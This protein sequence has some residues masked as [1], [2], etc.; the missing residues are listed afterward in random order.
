MHQ[1]P[2]PLRKGSSVAIVSPSGPLDQHDAEA[3]ERGCESLRSY[4]WEP[5]VIGPRRRAPAP[6]Y[7]AATDSGRRGSLR[8]AL[9]EFDAVVFSRGGY[10]SARLLEGSG[11]DIEGPWMMGFSDATALLWARYRAGLLGGVHGPCAKD[12]ATDPQWSLDRAAALLSGM[13]IESLRLTHLCGPATKV[14]G[15]IIAGNLTVACS[16]LAT[17]HMPDTTGHILVLEDVNEP[18]YK[19]DRMLTQWRLAGR[20]GSVAAVVF[21]VF[22]AVPKPDTY[23]V[24]LERTDDLG[25]PV[26]CTIDVGHHGVC[27]ALPIGRSASISR[28]RLAL[29]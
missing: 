23:E 9:R 2:P 19:V 22:D 14:S 11:W 7:L 13:S 15:P 10:G 18:P 8:R 25:I 16:L 5:Q 12:F 24:L 29:A 4:G 20:L 27:A 21:G 26:Y 1:S 28:S 17:P 3:V 6:P